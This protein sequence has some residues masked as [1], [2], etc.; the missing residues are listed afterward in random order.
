MRIHLGQTGGNRKEPSL[1]LEGIGGGQGTQGGGNQDKCLLLWTRKK[2]HGNG[3]QITYE[4]SAGSG[5]C[6]ESVCHECP[7]G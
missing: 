4:C 7:S 3:G 2:L 5:R 6:L 1:H